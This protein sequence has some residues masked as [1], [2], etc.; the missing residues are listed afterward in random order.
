MEQYGTYE[1]DGVKLTAWEAEGNFTDEVYGRL[2]KQFGVQPI[3]EE[4]LKRFETLT[5]HKP[6]RLLRRGLFFAHRQIDKI[7]DDF[8]K[9]IPIFIYTGRGPSGNLH[10][11]HF[12]VMEFTVW[13]QKVFNAVVVFQIAD[14]EKYWF[15]DKSFDEI[16]ELG[17]Q[18]TVDI[19]ALGFDPKK[20]F[21]FSNHDFSGDKFYNRIVCDMLKIVRIKDI[22]AIFGIQDEGSSGQ[23]LWPIY[24]STAAFSQAFNGIFGTKH[25]RCLV[26]YAIDQ[27]P[28][29]RLCRDVAPKL[30]F[31]RPCSIM[32]QFLPSLEGNKKMSTSSSLASESSNSSNPSNP[33][34]SKK[35]TLPK[36]SSTICMND[37]SEQVF[38]KI[39]KYAFS[40]G[41]DTL[42]KHRELGGR[43]DVDVSYQWLRHFLEDDEQLDQI[44][45]DYESGKLLTG[46]LKKI[47]SGV[48]SELVSNHQYS[49][50]KVTKKD[51]KTFC[52]IDNV[53]L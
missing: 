49:K 39:K 23:L 22:K 35:Q 25:V 13:L 6:H 52:R 9:G 27:D 28:Y 8:E 50:S 36:K 38:T 53:E 16:Y 24:Q 32:C 29:F 19:I 51:V 41:Q 11:G 30:K 20:T 15:K 31:M 17:K 45:R 33:L 48:I 37:T 4:L 21:I 3:T 40:G 12:V 2:I 5:G 26:A 47:C 10:L 7:L 44:K 42:E 34:K 18:N 1:K 14:D 43:T 46:E